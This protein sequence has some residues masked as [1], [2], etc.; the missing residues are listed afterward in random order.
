[1]DPYQSSWSSVGIRLLTQNVL[2]SQVALRGNCLEVLSRE[3]EH[4][5]REMVSMA[6]MWD[7]ASQW[8]AVEDTRSS[9]SCSYLNKQKILVSW[10]LDGKR[11]LLGGMGG[12]DW[13]EVKATGVEMLA[14]SRSEWRRDPGHLGGLGTGKVWVKWMQVYQICL[15]PERAE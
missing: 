5:G 7:L 13:Y 6:I 15:Q 14:A 12:K 8:L 1:M 4:L 2:A 10:I 9:N 11:R 3:A